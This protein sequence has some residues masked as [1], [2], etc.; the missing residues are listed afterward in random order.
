MEGGR[1]EGR[2]DLTVA[3]LISGEGLFIGKLCMGSGGFGMVGGIGMVNREVDGGWL[4]DR[5]S[6]Q[7]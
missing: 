5:G 7:G 3:R 4:V 1:E 6:S 2:V